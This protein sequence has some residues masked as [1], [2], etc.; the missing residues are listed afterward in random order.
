MRTVQGFGSGKWK[1]CRRK[2]FSGD[3][4]MRAPAVAKGTPGWV[5]ALNCVTVPGGIALRA[6]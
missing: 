1:L 3:L 6:A 2:E 5:V 4:E